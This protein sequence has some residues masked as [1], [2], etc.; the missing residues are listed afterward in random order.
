[1]LVV[2]FCFNQT[3]NLISV[4]LAMENYQKYANP[5]N[6]TIPINNIPYTDN[7]GQNKKT[8]LVGY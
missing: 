2:H 4:G 3:V 6:S 1:M 5:L 7:L 8:Y